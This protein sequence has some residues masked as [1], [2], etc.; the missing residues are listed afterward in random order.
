MPDDG[1]PQRVREYH[2]HHLDSTRWDRIEHR[3]GDIVISTSAKAGTTWTQRIVSLLVF[4]AGP[5]PMSLNEI[6]PWIDMRV[7]FP[8]DDIVRALELVTP[9]PG[10]VTAPD[11]LDMTVA[12][13]EVEEKLPGL[14]ES[15]DPDHP[16]M[17]RT[18]TVDLDLILSGEAWLELDDGAEVLIRTGDCVVVN[19][20]RHAW[21]NRAAA[22]CVMMAVCIGAHP[23]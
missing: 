21:S 1:S 14:P 17:H 23:A 12:M 19:G 3:P 8:I 6:S 16:G 5:L 20:Q 2:N 4:G 22:P 7:P 15:L 13:A 10:K 18:S 11:D 9:A